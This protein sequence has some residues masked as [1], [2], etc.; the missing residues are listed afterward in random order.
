M[1]KHKLPT[2]VHVATT[3]DKSEF[4]EFVDRWWR[5][6][7]A[8]ALLIA[9]AVLVRQYMKLRSG[10]AASEGWDALRKELTFSQPG[11]GG[12]IGIPSAATLFNLGDQL[13]ES[14]SGAWARVLEVKKRM[15]DADWAGASAALDKLKSEHPDHMLCRDAIELEPGSPPVTVVA[16]LATLIAARQSW[17][18]SHP[19]LFGNTALPEGS[20]RVRITT[21]AGA[22]VVQLAAVAAPKH[23]ENFIKLCSSGYY[24]GTKFHR[25]APDMMIQGG[26]PNSREGAVETWGLGGPDE[27]LDPE[28]SGLFH[29]PWVLSTAKVEGDPKESGSQFFITV[30]NAHHLDGKHSV[31]G[32][33]VEGQD[34]ARSIATAKV[35]DGTDRPEN[36][37]VIEKTEVL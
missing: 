19:A 16:R 36:P 30:A 12:A 26:D 31:F 33:L 23:T 5:A 6:G 18:S 21:S 25:V 10:R 32:V 20:P 34:V 27:K 4:A 35:V 17:R 29:F 24:V 7:L 22:L 1:A 37:V 2:Q 11:G 15:D 13:R 3:A 8:V 14:S 28:A 9:G